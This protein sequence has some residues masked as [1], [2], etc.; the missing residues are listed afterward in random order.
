MNMYPYFEAKVNGYLRATPAPNRAG[1]GSG[2]RFGGSWRTQ[3][4]QEMVI[5]AVTK[6]A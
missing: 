5:W 1:F 4:S 6:L 2:A 3:A